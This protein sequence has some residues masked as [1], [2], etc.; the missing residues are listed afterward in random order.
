VTLLALL[1]VRNPLASSSAN[2]VN[3]IANGHMLSK[4]DTSM[5]SGAEK[6]RK[7]LKIRGRMPHEQ[8]ALKL[9]YSAIRNAKNK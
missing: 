1:C 3:Y 6:M 4:A 2:T 9:L 5:T 8:A 7:V